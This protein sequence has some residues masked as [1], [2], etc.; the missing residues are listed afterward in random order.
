MKLDSIVV[1]QG[2]AG[3]LLAYSLIQRDRSFI[4][5]DR[6][7]THSASNVAT[8]LINPVICRNLNTFWRA[9][10]LM[11]PAIETFREMEQALQSRF[12]WPRD[13][14][15][16]FYSKAERTKLLARLD[17]KPNAFVGEIIEK[18][19][20]G[21][22]A[23]WG[24]IAIHKSAYLDFRQM[25]VDMRSHLRDMGILLEEK[26]RY[27]HFMLRDTAVEYKGY[28]A[29]RVIFAEGAAAVGNP[30]FKDLPFAATKGELITVQC[31]GLPQDTIWNIGYN[32]LPVGEGH[33]KYG[34]TY[35][36]DDPTPD[37]TEQAKVHLA[38]KLEQYLAVPFEVTGHEAGIRP[39]VTDRKPLLGTS[40]HDERL[41]L[42]N[43]LGSHGAIVAPWMADHLLDHLEKGVPLLPEVDIKRNADG[44]N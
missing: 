31:P 20:E 21:I 16:V 12:F 10:E 42:F 25:I 33:F 3:T 15:R 34:A 39:T 40:P 37:K 36:W 38:E 28:Q 24:G 27:E 44:H 7:D 8:G 43:G 18:L 2:I 41:V 19:P 13:M 22:N 29:E 6:F 32:L 4:L 35:N 11:E 14:V 1:G 9:D 23:G 17:D 5:I 30:F 26:A